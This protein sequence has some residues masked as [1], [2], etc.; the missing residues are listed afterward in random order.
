MER[1]KRKQD[2]STGHDAKGK[3]KSVYMIDT[4]PSRT[5]GI[6]CADPRFQSAFRRFISQELGID[7]YT[8]LVIGGGVRALGDQNAPP[9][10][11]ETLWGQIKF[12][13]TEANIEL[14]ILINHEDCKWYEYV[15][16]DQSEAELANIG[17]QDLQAADHRVRMEFANVQVRSF[18]AALENDTISFSEVTDG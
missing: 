13:I 14:V 2:G 15:H 4:Q 18:W 5:L 10:N 11:V 3:V 6:H 12:F 16:S 17:R 1:N 8:P 9:E 7:N